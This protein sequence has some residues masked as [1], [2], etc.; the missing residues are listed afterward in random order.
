MRAQAQT[1][2]TLHAWKKLKEENYIRHKIIRYSL[3]EEKTA[4]NELDK[5][6]PLDA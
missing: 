2:R 1:V 3:P 6:A 4:Q 5:N